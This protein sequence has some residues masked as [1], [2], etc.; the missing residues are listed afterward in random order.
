MTSV[1]WFVSCVC[2]WR[3]AN[4]CEE[5]THTF[6]RFLQTPKYHTKHSFKFQFC[7]FCTSHHDSRISWR[8]PKT[9][10]KH[11]QSC[12]GLMFYILGLIWRPW[13]A[14]VFFFILSINNIIKYKKVFRVFIKITNIYTLKP[15][16]GW[17]APLHNLQIS[18]THLHGFQVRQCSYSFFQPLIKTHKNTNFTKIFF[19]VLNQFKVG[20]S[21]TH[22]SGYH[23]K[24][25]FRVFDWQRLTFIS[26]FVRHSFHNLSFSFEIS[27]IWDFFFLFVRHQLMTL[28][29]RNELTIKIANLQARPVCCSSF[30]VIFHVVPRA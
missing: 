23:S 25:V 12:F 11:L 24:F 8:L 2:E 4:S 7:N 14:E 21:D 17:R 22:L 10:S 5:S 3:I 9:R 16:H 26:K 19:L 29:A 30:I 27:F 18:S 6:S 20:S 13:R 28:I 15:K 1:W